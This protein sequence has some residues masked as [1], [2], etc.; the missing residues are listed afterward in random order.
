MS[1]PTASNI[2]AGPAVLYVAPVGSTPPPITG[3]SEWPI[4]WPGSWIAVGYTDKGVTLTY[5][6]TVKGYTPDEE[7]SP[8]YD[9]LMAEKFELDV[10]LSESTMANLNDAISASTLT[11]DAVNGVTTVSAGSQALKY[12]ALGVAGPAPAGT[13]ASPAKGRMLI[14]QKAIAMGAIKYDFTR[15]STVMYAAKFEARK[16]A[17]QDLFDLYEFESSAS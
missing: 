12:V 15:K 17:G 11:T 5:T 6:P 9:I 16:I 1:E 7:T 4:V 8:V 10:T 3:T 14:V 2:V 13:G